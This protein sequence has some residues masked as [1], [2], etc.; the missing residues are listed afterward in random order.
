VKLAAIDIGSN[1]VR[2]LIV[3]AF[4]KDGQLFTQ[5][6][7]M[8]RVPLRLGDQ[9]FLDGAILPNKVEKLKK[10]MQSF[11]NMMDVCSV[12]HY[13]A[14]ATS[15]M[16]DA[17]NGKEVMKMIKKQAKIEIDV[18]SGKKESEIIYQSLK[19]TLENHPD[20]YFINID[21][22]GGSTELIVL[23][24]PKVIGV[25]S[26]QIGTIRLLNDMVEENEWDN[27]KN[28]LKKHIDKKISPIGFGTGGNIRKL[29]K[30]Y[31]TNEDFFSYPKMVKIVTHINDMSLKDRMAIYSL[32]YD[33]ADVI[34]PAS[35]IYLQCMKWGN[36]KKLFVPKAAGLVS[37]IINELFEE[38]KKL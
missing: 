17:A 10:T 11:R 28:W 21:V 22:G 6:D 19:P 20:D 7:L 33:R 24:G 4:E 15:A 14:C 37:G 31:L 5:K 36:I 27:M 9:V 30:L 23:N 8:V 12:E 38:R 34:A 3:N 32:R 29:K 18:I 26:F 1:A 13:K 35:E 2:L 16:R 25:K